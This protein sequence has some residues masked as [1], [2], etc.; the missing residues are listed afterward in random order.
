MIKIIHRYFRGRWERFYLKNHWHLVLDLSLFIVII[1]LAAGAISL[2]SYRPN[3]PWLVGFSGPELD[4]SNPPLK[5]D[6]SLADSSLKIKEAAVLKINFKNNGAAKII[7]AKIDLTPLDQNFILNRLEMGDQDFSGKINGRQVVLAPISPG[8]GGEVNLK[9]YFTAK[10]AGERTI[11]WQ[12]KSEY[13]FGKKLLKETI[14]LPPI[15]LAAE[16]TGKNFVYYTSPQGDQLGI[17]PIPPIAGI[18]T[19]YWIFWEA[20]SDGDFKNLVFS[21]RLP[22]GVELT[23]DRSLLAGEFN[24]NAAARQ[25]IWKVQELQGGKD[26]Y[27]LGFEIQLIPIIE[28]VGQIL[29]LLTDCQYYAEDALTGQEVSGKFNPL[30]T[31]LEGDRF[32]QGRGEVVSQ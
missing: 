29:P 25:L 3:I 26:S 4:L 17:G 15:T 20:E 13:I 31:N 18:P 27:R 12:A 22:Q 30:T 16:L 19:N 11:N 7:S 5:L 21:A 1:I 32:N 2:Y 24:Y 23:D 14:A 6:F 8:A 10:N 28:Q 9:V